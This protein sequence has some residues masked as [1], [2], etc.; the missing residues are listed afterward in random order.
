MKPLISIVTATF[1]SEKYIKK[2]AECIKLQSYKDWEWIIVD[3]ASTDATISILAEI[4][5]NHSN[6]FYLINEINSG[7]AVSRNRAL[8]MAK[9]EYIAF[10]DSD[11]LWDVNKLEE[12]ISY[13]T[14]RDIK[15]SFTA[16]DVIDESGKPLDLKIDYN[17]NKTKFNYKDML[18]K[19]ATLGC[20]TVI[21]KKD[22]ISDLSM[23]LIR[24][25]QDYAFWLKILKQEHNAYLLK[26]ILTHYRIVPGSIS[27]NKIKKAKRQW[28][29][30]R[31]IE[32]IGF[33]VSVYYFINYA[34]RAILRG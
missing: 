28:E 24:T 21:I 23:P 18:S 27:R 5:N 12:Q 6:I 9:G 4:A 19:K 33:F 22:I 26:S 10:I 17:N 3:D 11:D 8:S 13:M 34:V 30:Y 31:K 15:F 1:N 7:A 14:S 16:Y 25:G 2:V 29:I 32:G 20:S